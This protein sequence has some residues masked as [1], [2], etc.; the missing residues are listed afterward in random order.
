MKTIIKE[1]G[2]SQQ[3]EISDDEMD[4][5]NFVTLYISNSDEESNWDEITIGIDELLRAIKQYEKK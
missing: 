5:N 4:N 1:F 3:L 2:S